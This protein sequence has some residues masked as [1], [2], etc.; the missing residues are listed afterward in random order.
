MGIQFLNTEQ[1][2]SRSH[3]RTTKF[4]DMILP[5]VNFGDDQGVGSLEFDAKVTTAAKKSLRLSLHADAQPQSYNPSGKKTPRVLQI[6]SILVLKH[7][8]KLCYI[9]MFR[10]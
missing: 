3:E 2:E 4:S 1:E 6:R 9:R 7:I 10:K 5:S 8:F